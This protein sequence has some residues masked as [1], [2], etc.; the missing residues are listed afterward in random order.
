MALL[1][2]TKN[3]NQIEPARRFARCLLT[4]NLHYFYVCL[5]CL[6]VCRTIGGYWPLAR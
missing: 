3:L 2:W 5:S 6:F 4:V 1:I